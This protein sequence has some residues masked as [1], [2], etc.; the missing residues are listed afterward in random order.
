MTYVQSNASSFWQFEQRYYNVRSFDSNFAPIAIT[1][2]D[3]SKELHSTLYYV[4]NIK[5]S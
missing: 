2:E 3:E 5:D 4:P 1:K